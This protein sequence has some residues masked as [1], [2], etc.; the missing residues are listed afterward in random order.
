MP[1]PRPSL[2]PN[3]ARI[4]AAHPRRIGRDGQIVQLVEEKD[5]AWHVGQS[6]WGGNTD[7][8]SASIGIELD[9]D[10]DKPF[11]DA[12]IDVF[13]TL[14]GDLQQRYTV[15]R[16]TFVDHADVAPGRK[17]DPSAWFPWR[18]LADDSGSLVQ[19]LPPQAT[20]RC[21]TASSSSGQGMKT[22]FQRLESARTGH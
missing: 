14:L 17:V 13:L 22:A 5:R 16:A 21:P 1:H 20:K 6:W 4:R 3:P 18:K 9:N 10:G 8:N 19:R 2:P 7:I 12:Q 15:L 11:S